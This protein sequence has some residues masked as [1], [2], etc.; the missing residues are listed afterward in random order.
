MA[1][2]VLLIIGIIAFIRYYVWKRMRRLLTS[3]VQVAS[4]PVEEI[5]RKEQETEQSETIVEQSST[6]TEEK[7]KTNRL[8]E[9][10][11]KE[12]HKKTGCLCRERKALY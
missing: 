7:Y 3:P 12:L 9:E 6:V 11:C 5:S 8:T 1:L 4:T 2:F 10:E